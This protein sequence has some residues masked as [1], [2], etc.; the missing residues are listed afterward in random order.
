MNDD[1]ERIITNSLNERGAGASASDAGIDAVYRRVDRRRTRRRSV[2]AIG[3]V[4][5]VAV[6]V[7]A[8][9]NLGDDDPLSPAAPPES[10]SMEG[11]LGGSWAEVVPA[12]TPLYRCSGS[13]LYG[14]A[15]GNSYWADCESVTLPDDV[16][17]VP[18]VVPTTISWTGDCLATTV[19]GEPYATSVPCVIEQVPA[20]TVVWCEPYGTAPPTSP[21][22]S[23]TPSTSPVTTVATFACGTAPATSTMPTT[24][25]FNESMATTTTIWCE[26]TDDAVTV[27]VP[28]STG[29]T[30]DL[31]AE[32]EQR[33]VIVVGDTWSSIADRFGITVEL[34]AAYNEWAE[35]ET[36][37]ALVGE[38]VLIP[39]GAVVPAD[40][41]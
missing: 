1:L 9:A 30:G 23:P 22:T 7:V 35:P 14:D 26:T 25:G 5:L 27:T 17:V 29:P 3:S 8:I 12:G 4:A 41:R 33:Y 11:A 21:T 15:E 6:G 31:V 19:P 40:D 34:L 2:A 32:A 13:V 18:N 36:Q 37:V 10:A 38:T 39:P 28:C 16:G 24:P 20:T